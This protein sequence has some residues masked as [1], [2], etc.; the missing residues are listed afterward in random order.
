MIY[1]IILLI[2][3]IILVCPINILVKVKVAGNFVDLKIFLY[4][5]IRVI[6]IILEFFSDRFNCKGTF[7]FTKKYIDLVKGGGK[8]KMFLV[9]AIKLNEISLIRYIRLD[10]PKKL[11]IEQ[12]VDIVASSIAILISNNTNSKLKYAC[13]YTINQNLTQIRLSINTSILKILIEIFKN[14]EKT[15]AKRPNTTNS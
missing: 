13:V 9:K 5:F 4:S 11:L 3:I 1:L 6:S 14:K 15:Y 8:S 2:L 7:K 10:K 12:S